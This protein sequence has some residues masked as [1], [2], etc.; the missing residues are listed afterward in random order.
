MKHEYYQTF[1]SYIKKFFDEY[2][3]RGIEICCLTPNNEPLDGLLPLFSFN[4]MLWWP[5]KVA[6]WVVDYLAPTLS[7]AGYKDLVYMAVDDQRSSLPWYPDIMFKNQKA[8]ELFSGIAV[9]WY[10][11]E[12]FS[13]NRLT[14]THTKYPDKFILMTEAC[15]GKH[16]YLFHNK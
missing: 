1:A 12:I 14:E 9:H 3:K 6:E 7:N 4:S 15:T 11:D 5:N 2:K 10:A 13:P 16:N 8:K